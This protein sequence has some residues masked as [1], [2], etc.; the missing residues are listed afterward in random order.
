MTRRSA[1]AARLGTVLT[2]RAAVVFTLGTPARRL[3]SNEMR[4]MTM[5]TEQND[6]ARVVGGRVR[7]DEVQCWP[8][9]FA[10][11]DEAEKHVRKILEK[12]WDPAD[13]TLDEDLW[14]AR[15]QLQEK[16]FGFHVYIEPVK[17]RQT[18]AD[19]P[20]DSYENL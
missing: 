17:L 3:S 4:M 12:M 10:D 19:V 11:Y 16:H 6:P 7:G 8:E 5:T 9:L 20:E 15:D 14:E 2:S 18:V 1:S 13:G